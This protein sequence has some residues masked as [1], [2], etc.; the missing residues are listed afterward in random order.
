MMEVWFLVYGR[1]WSDWWWLRVVVSSWLR[2][3]LVRVELLGWG[4]GWVVSCV[5]GFVGSWL[6]CRVNWKVFLKRISRRCCRLIVFCCGW[7]FL[8]NLLLLDGFLRVLLVVR[9]KLRL[10]VS[11]MWRELLGIGVV[12]GICKW[13]VVCFGMRIIL[14]I[15]FIIGYWVIFGS[16]VLLMVKLSGYEV[17]MWLSGLCFVNFLIRFSKLLNGVVGYLW[18]WR[19]CLRSCVFFMCGMVVCCVWLLMGLRVD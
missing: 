18:Y 1:I 4:I 9:R 3:L 19:S 8:R 15:L 7:G 12:C 5:L 13:L 2:C 10:C 16:V 6:M 11:W 14:E 17:R